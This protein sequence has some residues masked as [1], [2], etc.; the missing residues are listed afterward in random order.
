MGR[1]VYGTRR[2]NSKSRMEYQS[3]ESRDLLAAIIVNTLTDNGDFSDGLISLREA[4]TATN[5]NAAFGDAPAGDESGDSI[6]IDPAL[7]GQTITLSG[8]QLSITDDLVIRGFGTTLEAGSVDGVGSRIFSINTS[9]R[10]V[11]S[12]LNFINGDVTQEDIFERRGGAIS[13]EGGGTL[14][15]FRSQF[16]N[17]S[18][19]FGGAIYAEGGT[20]IS[21]ESTFTSNTSLDDNGN[22]GGALYFANQSATA[23]IL[24][25]TFE[26][27]VAEQGD[28]GAISAGSSDQIFVFSSDFTNNTA[29]S[30]ASERDVFFDDDGDF[31][32][33]AIFTRGFLRV[34]Q[35]TFT[36][37]SASDGS[38]GAIIAGGSRIVVAN[39]SFENNVT[40]RAGGAVYLQSGVISRFNN[41]QFTNNEAISLDGGIARGGAIFVADPFLDPANEPFDPDEPPSRL[42]IRSSSFDNNSAE[43]GG[44]IF[45]ASSVFEGQAVIS[46]TTFRGNNVGGRANGT[47]IGSGGAI[48]NNA[49][50]LQINNSTF[51]NN[52]A[53]KELSRSEG[54][55]VYSVDGEVEIA[56]S[57]FSGNKADVGGAVAVI[58]LREDSDTNI[59]ESEFRNNRAGLPAGD[60]RIQSNETQ[61]IGDGGAIFSNST[62]DTNATVEIRGGLFENNIASDS[63]GAVAAGRGINDIVVFPSQNGATQFIG[64][65]ALAGDGGAISNPLS[66]RIR[67]AVFSE[68]TARNGGGIFVG[69]PN[70]TI[71]GIPLSGQ[72]ILFGAQI[73]ENDARVNGG[74]VFLA[75][76]ATFINNSSTINLNTATNGADIFEE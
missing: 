32:G 68:N 28:G 65:R 39:T 63:G 24:S 25:S 52:E 15:L 58:S 54:G 6:R 29:N 59:F 21:V 31:G 34:G 27:N 48:Y 2:R 60:P 7:A 3:L 74:G 50:R 43:T 14:Q 22:R 62:F 9:E 73:T 49:G 69:D 76:N 5:T 40:D 36:D 35:S 61:S 53:R 51:E 4:I 66:T 37:N 64:N 23:I 44:A 57:S 19:R 46:G 56:F 13:F 70:V 41:V 26:G 47:S 16:S 75:S 67:D 8:G 1:N 20:V 72:L 33:G 12:R 38:G 55:A 10:V 42:D 17:N 71:D 30:N 45:F 11:L 18:A